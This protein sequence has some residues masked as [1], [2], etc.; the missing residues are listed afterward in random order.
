MPFGG[1]EIDLLPGQQSNATSAF[2]VPNDTR[3][4][5]GL[6]DE[7][8]PPVDCVGKGGILLNGIWS[9]DDEGLV[10]DLLVPNGARVQNANGFAIGRA[11]K[12]EASVAKGTTSIS[13]EATF[14]VGA[15]ERSAAPDR[16]RFAMAL[17]VARFGRVMKDEGESQKPGEVE[18]GQQGQLLFPFGEVGVDE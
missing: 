5:G 7:G 9:A 12:S 10:V 6:A 3:M 14:V 16:L 18:K 11:T 13:V 2:V 4:N 17:Y 1:G 15:P 8:V